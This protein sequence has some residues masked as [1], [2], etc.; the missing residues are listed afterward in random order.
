MI[1]EKGQCLMDL[2]IQYNGDASAI[3]AIALAN[4]ISPTEEVNPGL[5]LLETEIVNKPL[6][7]FFET[8]GYK[9]A[10][11]EGSYCIG[12]IGCWTIGID[13]LIS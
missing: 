13:F 11:D 1:V 4:N 2:A 10:T 3:F 8:N 5:E 9:P 7:N 6:F 12:G